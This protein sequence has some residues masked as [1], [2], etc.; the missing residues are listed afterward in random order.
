MQVIETKARQS[1]LKQEL[2]ARVPKEPQKENKP[3]EPPL[4]EI[5]T[6]DDPGKI[7]FFRNN[8]CVSEIGF[9][10]AFVLLRTEKCCRKFEFKILF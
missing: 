4:E 7:G 5:L 9:I 6:T 1:V 8:I 3:K 2:S 10:G